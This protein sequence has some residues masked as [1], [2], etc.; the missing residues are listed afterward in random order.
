MIDS[1]HKDKQ[2]LRPQAGD[3]Q[4]RILLKL[5]FDIWEALE[6]YDRYFLNGDSAPAHPPSLVDNLESQIARIPSPACFV[7]ELAFGGTQGFPDCDPRGP[8]LGADAAKHKPT[9]A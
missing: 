5:V 8:G 4:T 6:K 9:A 3:A 7:A 1:V 2:E